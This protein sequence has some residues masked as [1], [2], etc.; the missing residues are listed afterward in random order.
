MSKGQKFTPEFRAEAVEL[1]NSSQKSLFE[2]A[3][4]LESIKEHS[5]TG[6]VLTVLSTPRQ[7]PR[8]ADQLTGAIGKAPPGTGRG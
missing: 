6:F 2:V 4:S 7:K 1:V 8:Y 5:A 3:E